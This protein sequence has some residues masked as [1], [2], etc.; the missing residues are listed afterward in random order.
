[1]VRATAFFTRMIPTPMRAKSL[2]ELAKTIHTLRIA[3]ATLATLSTALEDSRV[4]LTD[5]LTCDE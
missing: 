1:M 5:R 3:A 2:T 4:D